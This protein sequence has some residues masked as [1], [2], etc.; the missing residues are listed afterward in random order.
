MTLV[1]LAHWTTLKA[2]IWNV[3]PSGLFS[4]SICVGS[5]SETGPSGWTEEIIANELAL[6]QI[7]DAIDPDVTSVRLSCNV[8]TDV[9]AS[10]KTTALA[11]VFR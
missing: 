4:T 6:P 9:C 7:V 10:A 8:K 11:S 5:T 1:R 3:E 2:T